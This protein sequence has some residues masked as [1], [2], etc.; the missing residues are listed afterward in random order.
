MRG[1]AHQNSI[2]RRVVRP[3]TGAEQPGTAL[4]PDLFNKFQALIYK[5]AGIWLAPHKEALLTGRLSKRLRFL[6]IG[7]MA[8]YYAFVTDADQQSER[9]LMIDC[10]TTNETRFFRE[11]RHFEVLATQIF[12]QWRQQAAAGLRSTHVR[13]WSAGCSTG[14][15]PY[16]LAM[17]FRKYF[18]VE[19][20]WT[21][22]I[23]ATDIS[24]RVLEKARDGLYPITRSQDIP[25][26]FLLEFMLRGS[27]DHEQWMKVGPEIQELV[28]FARL[29]LHAESYPVPGLFDLI[30]CRNVLI[31]FDN[32]GKKKVIEGLLRH[33]TP[34]GLLFVG[35]SESLGGLAMG[36]RTVIPTVYSRSANT[37]AF[38]PDRKAEAGSC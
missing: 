2:R 17:L 5:E 4:P 13:I 24:N 3:R 23:L 16:S 31:Y 21:L 22:E 10:I 30:F 32:P 26:H 7:S 18:P 25:R 34:S 11:P 38:S 1:M 27:G 12:P 19:S 15:E 37:H 28:R 33:L 9:A 20:G 29:N 35:H 8:D 36:L 6:G 14:E